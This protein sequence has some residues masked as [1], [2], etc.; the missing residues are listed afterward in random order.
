MQTIPFGQNKATIDDL[1]FWSDKRSLRL[2]KRHKMYGDH[3]YFF[4]LFNFKIS[5]ETPALV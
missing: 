1:H 3:Q 2:D 5:E 4:D